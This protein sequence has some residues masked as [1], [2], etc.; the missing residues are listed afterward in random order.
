MG[1]AGMSRR[2]SLRLDHGRRLWIL[3]GVATKFWVLDVAGPVVPLP[4]PTA[5]WLTCQIWF[6]VDGSGVAAA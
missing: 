6:A 1:A 4:E 2:S 3:Y 5:N